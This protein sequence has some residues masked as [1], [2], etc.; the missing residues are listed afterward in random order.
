MVICSWWG[1]LCAQAAWRGYVLRK[2]W[3]ARDP[4]RLRR[5]AAAAQM[6]KAFREILTANQS[7]VCFNGCAE[8]L[9]VMQSFISHGA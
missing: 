7:Q 4:E 8:Y 3:V 6:H 1:I 5:E 2:L 9:C